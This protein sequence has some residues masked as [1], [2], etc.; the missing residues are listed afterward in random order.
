MKDIPRFSLNIDHLKYPRH[1]NLA[2][3]YNYFKWS[4]TANR[5]F[6]FSIIILT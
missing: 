5:F 4:K 3:L 6:L 2:V 1:P